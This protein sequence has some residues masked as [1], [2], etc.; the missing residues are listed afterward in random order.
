[1]TNSNWKW[2]PLGELFDIGAGKT[3]SA[4]ARAGTDKVPFLRTSN[5]LWDEIDLTEVDEMSISPDEL[6]DKSVKAGDLLVCE[7]GEI[8]RAAVWDGGVPIMSFQNHLHRLRPIRDD[9]D[10]RFYVYFLQ[11]A[12]TQL[13]IFEGVG[14]KTTIPN[15]SRNRLAS[16]D[17]P[18]PPLVEQRSIAQSLAKVRE[19]ITIH[20]K[21]TSTAWELKQAVMND[22]FARGLRGA[23]QK[24]TEFCVMPENWDAV[25]LGQVCALSTGTTPATKDKHYY[26]GDIPFIKTADIVNN[27]IST[28]NTFISQKAVDDYSLKLFPPGTV[29][30]AMYGQGKT[31]GQVSLLEIAAATTQN[32]AAIQPSN[33]MDSTFLWHYLMS[34]YE[35]LRGMGSLGHV[36]HLNLGYLRDLLVVMPPLAEQ[37]EIAEILNAL[38]RKFDLHH[39]KRTVLDE[40]FK[41]MLHKL[42][43]G[44]IRGDELDL[45][46]LLGTK[47]DS[48]EVAA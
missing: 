29:L 45:S 11:S 16:L 18:H 36:S 26:E 44:E 2:R 14:N 37:K 43:T 27:R 23:A 4:A 31:R 17:V 12:F 32:A 39:K 5:V 24:E 48:K 9:I 1:M 47:A 7:G 46:V 25:R 42:M 22:L 38:D 8:G 41:A 28:A 30:M 20:D 10:A 3:M 40:L 15:L 21:A 6:V 19:A 33:V 34:C 13:G 35:R